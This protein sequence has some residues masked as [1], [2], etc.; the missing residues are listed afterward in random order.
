MFMSDKYT[1]RQ[2][3]IAR[4]LSS[5][6]LNRGDEC[7]FSLTWRKGRSTGRTHALPYNSVAPKLRDTMTANT[8]T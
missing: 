7:F 1:E 6:P 3:S 4:A 8:P 2:S 5:K